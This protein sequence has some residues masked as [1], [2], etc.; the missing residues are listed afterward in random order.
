MGGC[1]DDGGNRVQ[2]D[3]SSDCSAGAWVAAVA[4]VRPFRQSL[5]LASLTDFSPEVHR[6]DQ[7]TPTKLPCDRPQIVVNCLSGGRMSQ[8]K[9]SPPRR[10]GYRFPTAV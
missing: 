10:Q 1:A 2:G 7:R 8:R 6:T 5:R 4:V 3:E 9:K